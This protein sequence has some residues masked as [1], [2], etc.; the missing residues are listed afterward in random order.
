ME[1]RIALLCPGPSLLSRFAPAEEWDFVV[2]VNSAA[3]LYPVDWLVFSDRHIITPVTS[4]EHPRPRVGVVTNGAHELWPG[5]VRRRMP[6]QDAKSPHLTLAMRE[7]AER[8]ATSEC[9]WTF[10]NALHFALR[11]AGPAGEVHVFGF[12]CTDDRLDV[13]GVEGQHNAGRWA[14]ELPW[15]RLVWDHRCHQHG[16]A[17]FP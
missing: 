8:Q 9:G 3:W 14:R 5:C 16:K 10:P 1:M 6:I 4:G 11:L 15:V 12:D 17:N 13:A 7:L 2:A